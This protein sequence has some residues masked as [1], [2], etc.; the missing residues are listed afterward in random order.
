VEDRQRF[1]RFVEEHM[2]VVYAAAYSA[3]GD[4]ALSEEVAQETFLCAWRKLPALDRPP[5]MPGWL[6]GIARMMARNVRRRRGREQPLLDEAPVSSA[7]SPLDVLLAREQGALVRRALARVPRRYREPLVLYYQGE[8][9]VHAV[10]AALGLSEEAVRQRLSRGRK[11]LRDEVHLVERELHRSRPRAGLAAAIATGFIPTAVAR[12]SS[13][14]GLLSFAPAAALACILGS[15][16]VASPSSDPLVPSVARLL[17]PDPDPDP[18]PDPEP[19]PGAILSFS[20][21]PIPRPLSPVPRT[22]RPVSVPEDDLA[23]ARDLLKRGFPS[24]ALP[25]LERIIQRGPSS[26]DYKPAIAATADIA[27]ALPDPSSAVALL[28]DAA[29][30]SPPPDIAYLL[31]R[32][33]YAGDPARALRLLDTVPATS[34]RHLDARQ[35]AGVIHVRL[36]QPAAAVRA[37][38]SV[39]AAASTSRLPRR[40]RDAARDRALLDL[41]RLHYGA[42]RYTRALEA[43]SRIPRRSPAWPTAL[44]EST[45]AYLRTGDAARGLGH[46]HSLRS[47]YL[48]GFPFPE[49]SKVEAVF[50]FQR[51]HF[52]RAQRVT[53]DFE[54]RY[55]PVL[56]SL[57]RITAASPGDDAGFLSSA[58]ALRAAPPSPFAGSP[59]R[60]ASAPDRDLTRLFAAAALDDRDVDRAIA[61]VREIDQ[62]LA[63]LA[64]TPAVWRASPLASSL[65]TDLSVER[66]LAVH[67]AG[68]LARTRLTRAADELRALQGDMRRIRIEILEIRAAHVGGTLP[69]EPEPTIYAIDDQA[70]FWPWDGEYWRDEVGRYYVDLVPACR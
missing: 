40:A 55:R 41:G 59:A 2:A 15:L 68:R 46:I 24:G 37:F 67:A 8:E 43:F 51:C 20:P 19:D 13:L 65:V 14:A 17:V 11:H 34:P 57:D 33:H 31:A 42:R 12:A 69:A 23:S 5:A 54:V 28:A 44:F 53:R 30:D 70:S 1:A 16:S 48:D 61:R 10:A 47:P 64:R 36:G 18:E 63:R 21:D 49:A 38:E 4:R 62:E 29:L 45:W 39:V 7:P 35:L 26:P 52:R 66:D 22:P 60:A 3:T 25:H 58:L 27:R 9:S 6:C 32:H 50:Y 56:A